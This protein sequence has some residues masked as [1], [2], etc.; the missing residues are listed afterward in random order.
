[1]VPLQ[2]VRQNLD[3]CADPTAI[4]HVSPFFHRLLDALRGLH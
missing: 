2:H 1:L 4:P 3:C